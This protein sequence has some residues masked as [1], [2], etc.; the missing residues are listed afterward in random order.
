LRPGVPG[1][2]ETIRV[3]SVIGRFLEHHR[4]FY[5]YDGGKEHVYLSSA[6]WMER[7]FFRRIELCFPVLDEKLKK[8]VIAEG[9]KAYL[10][11]NQQTWEM[12]GDGGF[13]RKR[14]PRAQPH[15]A[16]ADLMTTLGL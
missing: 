8:R 9:L 11:D 3:R 12:D 13:A 7:N 5:F 4:I 1:L 16:Q 15:S 14:S 6:D 2:S 10:A